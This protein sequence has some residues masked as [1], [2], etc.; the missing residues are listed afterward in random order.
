MVWYKLLVHIINTP[1]GAVKCQ[2]LE[3]MQAVNETYGVLV[4]QFHLHLAN[5]YI[6][7]TVND[8]IILICDRL[9][10]KYN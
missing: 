6:I 5:S 8:K 3:F 1:P 7:R 10:W 9:S 4:R 2:H